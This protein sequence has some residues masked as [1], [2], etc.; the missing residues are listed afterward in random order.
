[1]TLQGKMNEAI[2][3]ISCTYLT[4]AI[5]FSPKLYSIYYFCSLADKKVEL[6]YGQDKNAHSLLVDIA[7]PCRVDK[8]HFSFSFQFGNII[9]G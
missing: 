6:G 5:L 3:I 8:N 1:M 7:D 4:C 9:L 2:Q